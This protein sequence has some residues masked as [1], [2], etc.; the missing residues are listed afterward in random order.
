[1]CGRDLGLLLGDAVDATTPGEDR[2]GV[3]ELDG[4]AREK[5]AE[6]PGRDLVVRVVE[7]AQDDAV[8]AQV[9]VDVRVV[10]PALV[11]LEDGRR[12]DLDD[13]RG[14]ALGVRLALELGDELLAQLVVGVGGV[15]L[16]VDQTT[17]GAANAATMST[18]PRVP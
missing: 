11:V 8:V 5:P 10:D 16:R 12:G 18:W 13:L 4:P 2:T 9:V 7:G 6:D 1:M 3:H 15:L 17:P 14:P